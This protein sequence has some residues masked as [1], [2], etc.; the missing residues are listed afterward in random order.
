MADGAALAPWQRLGQEAEHRAG[1]VMKRA[2]GND[3]RTKDHGDGRGELLKL[4]DQRLNRRTV[5]VLEEASLDPHCDPRLSFERA[6]LKEGRLTNEGGAER[7]ATTR[8][9][10]RSRS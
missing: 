4:F 1:K 5:T 2:R 6:G 8:A 10:V 3:L 7:A 9:Q